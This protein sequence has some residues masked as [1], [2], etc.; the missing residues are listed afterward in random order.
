MIRYS[1][2]ALEAI[3]C[4]FDQANGRELASYETS[5]LLEHSLNGEDPV[6]ISK[7][8]VDLIRRDKSLDAYYRLAVYWALSKR[9]D[10]ELIPFFVERLIIELTLGDEAIYQ[11]LIALDNLDEAV[12]GQDRDGSY[13][14]LDTDL[15]RRDAKLYLTK[16]S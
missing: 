10:K 2:D 5:Q 3:V 15:N 11:L 1:I 16:G 7:L 14:I 12:F 9:Y 6:S 4:L 8:L 13:S